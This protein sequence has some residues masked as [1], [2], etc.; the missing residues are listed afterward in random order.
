M[1]RLINRSL[2]LKVILALTAILVI[3][4]AL[5]CISIIAKQNNLLGSM[6]TTVHENLEGAGNQTQQR[7]ASLEQNVSVTLA[8][9]GD[10]TTEQLSRETEKSLAAEESNTRTAMEKLLESNAKAVGALLANIAAD[11]LMAKEYD[12]LIKFSQAIAKTSEIVYVIFLD[13]KGTILPSHLNVIDN[14]II[15]YLD[16]NHEGEDAEKVLTNSKKDSSVLIYEQP[17]EY[18]GLPLGKAVICLTKDTVNQEIAALMGRF[19]TLKKD[20]ANTVKSVLADESTK[21]IGQINSDLAQ[22]NV[23]N[24]KAQKETAAILVE[25]SEKVNT[26]TAKVIIAIGSA[27][28]VGIIVLLVFLLRQIVITPLRQ[29]TNGLKDAAEGEG[30]LTK[31]L[32]SSRTDE[33]GTL[34]GWFDSFVERINNI[35]VEINGNSETVSSSALEVL[36][37]SEQMQEEANGLSTS[38]DSVAAAS[39]EMNTSMATVAAASE[40]ASTNISIVAGTATEMKEA[41]EKVAE[42]CDEAK[43]ISN[44]ATDQV[45]RATDKV[46]RL[47]SAAEQISKVT[48]VIT[49]IAD[50][51]NLLALNATIEAARAGDAGKGFAVVAG[52]IKNLAKQTQEATKEIK[53]KIDG[54]QQ[55]TNDT[56]TEVGSITEVI[57]NVNTIMSKIAEAMLEQSSRASEVALNIEQASQGIAEVNENV[58]QTSLVSA[59][60]A[61]DISEV[62]NIAH[63][64]TK[65]SSNMRGNSEALSDL[66]NQLRKMI[67]SFKVSAGDTLPPNNDRIDREIAD[68]FPW[69]TKL[70]LGI[71]KIDDQH[72]ELVRLINRLHRA[73]KVKAGSSEAGDIL[74]NLAKYTLYH[75]D[76]EEKLFDK[77]GY[78][79]RKD[80]KNYHRKLVESVVVFQKDFKS[81]KTG[82]TMELMMFLT[83]WLK[84]HIMKTDRDYVAFFKDKAI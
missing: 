43:N 68:L 9:M 62:S 16:T 2:T 14:R 12:K 6:A 77:Y 8:R 28:C 39:E 10:Q 74:D 55:S 54:I 18:F 41:L 29:I 80:H 50:Q 66:A 31:R 71:D 67:S 75:F 40:E 34:A 33:I 59:Q 58:A 46:T 48:E 79:Q 32:N 64:M 25:A 42:S 20:N 13:E 83:N 70:S 72:K 82:L 23:D 81:G 27:C 3:A 84:D 35:I 78:P 37:S 11:P 5:L 63:S 61:Q 19:I 73:M 21:V 7:F 26:E 45:K 44:R 53:A 38:T 56:V 51:T 60:I 15:A 17:I 76:F 49:E 69:T 22:V 4:F 47:G 65:S 52:E 30:D 1:L 57:E 36:T 24:G